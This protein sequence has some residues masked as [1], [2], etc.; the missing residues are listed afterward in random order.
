MVNMFLALT[1]IHGESRDH[2]HAG[3]IEIHDW[4]WG[5]DNAAPFRLEA[6]D[7]AKQT[8]IQHLTIHKVF[9][10]ASVTLMNYCAHGRKIEEGKIT[11]R[12][13]DGNNQVEFLKII[14]TDVKVDG[15]KWPCRGEEIRGIPETVELSFFHFKIIYE[16]QI[17]DGSL[18]GKTEFEY[19]VPEEKQKAAK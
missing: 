10:K 11:C 12:K 3:E 6:K 2:I 14:L 16:M 8:Q 17:Q 9:D 15:V 4:E 7:A 5:V 19:D 1:N 13:N 18:S